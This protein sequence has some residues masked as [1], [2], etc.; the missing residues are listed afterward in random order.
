MRREAVTI[1]LA[2]ALLLP[3][4]A[5]AQHTLH[6]LEDNGPS[7]N[8]IDLL[9]MGDGYDSTEQDDLL[10]DAT[11]AVDAVFEE[12]PFAEYA[13]FFNVAV[14][15]TVSAESGADHPE[16][17]EYVDSFY[18][19]AYDCAGLDRAICCDDATVF[20][21]ASEQYPAFDSI[22]L[23][24]N[25][26]EYGGAGGAIAVVS[27][28]PMTSQIPLH[29]FGH[30]F[31][32]L[33][34]EYDDP[35]PAFTCTDIYPNVSF[36]ADR[37]ELKWNHWV[38]DE[39]PLPTPETEAL[40]HMDPVGAFEGACYQETGLYRPVYECVMRALGNGM[41]PI[42]T[43]ALVLSFYGYVEPIDE[44]SPA[45]A[46]VE[47]AGGDVL[48][49]V[50]EPV[51]PDP[52]TMTVFWTLDGT[53]VSYADGDSLDLP[54]SCVEQGEHKIAATVVDETAMVLDDPEDLLTQSV[55][56]IVTRTDDGPVDECG[57]DTDADSDTDTDPDND[58]DSDSDSGSDPD[59][60]DPG[61]SG[62][63]SGCGCEI[64]GTPRLSL[65]DVVLG[66]I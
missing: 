27:T 63:G 43:E 48:S 41:C 26:T 13:P 57:G 32:D 18:D 65:F 37:D 53:Q 16:E 64:A 51:R 2:A 30:T 25:D 12:W 10:D 66:M 62:G 6:M 55:S 50:V 7:A 22:L 28:N 56:W 34:D 49:F 59:A 40:T 45:G 9:V 60:A 31:A 35:Y 46:A 4:T 39:T 14:I 8:R 20:T 54:V 17:S 23:I 3:A 42:C 19:C 15:A 11:A 36:T 1:G 47:G 24:V 33:G 5:L 44:Y 58:T 38:L 61:D 52:D 21:V 29:E